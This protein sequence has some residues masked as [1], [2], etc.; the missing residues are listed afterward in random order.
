MS[1]KVALAVILFTCVLYLVACKENR[2]MQLPPQASESFFDDMKYVVSAEV[3]YARTCR[4]DP[5]IAGLF[6]IGEGVDRVYPEPDDSEGDTGRQ[7]YVYRLYDKEG[8]VLYHI[9]YYS[10]ERKVDDLTVLIIS[11]PNEDISEMRHY[12]ITNKDILNT[13]LSYVD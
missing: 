11:H 10:D 1:Q 8:T 9:Q 12:E 3:D 6:Y 5:T 13:M 2:D 4:A 7:D